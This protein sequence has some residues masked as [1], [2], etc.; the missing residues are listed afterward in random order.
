M[1][2]KAHPK[3]AQ[4]I[5]ANGRNFGRSYLRLEDYYC[6][7]STALEAVGAVATPSAMAPFSATLVPDILNPYQSYDLDKD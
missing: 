3:V 2:L 1:W 7:A 6:Y 5:A 4:R